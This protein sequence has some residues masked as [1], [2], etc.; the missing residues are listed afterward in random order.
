MK[1]T[2][3]NEFHALVRSHLIAGAY[4]CEGM[5]ES[6]IIAHTFKRFESEYNYTQNRQRIPNL[7]ARVAEWLSGLALSVA[8]NYC[9][10]IA[11]AEQWHETTLHD[12]DRNRARYHWQA[13]THHSH[14]AP[15]A[16]SP[17]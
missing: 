10:I 13:A 11:L 7:Q 3:T 2:N 12:K 15:L 1:R 8:Y 17:A 9:D 16:V 14:C 5:T 4:D 6:D